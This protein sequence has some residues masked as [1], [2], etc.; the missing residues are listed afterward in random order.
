MTDRPTTNLPKTNLTDLQSQLQGLWLPLVT[1]FRDGALDEPQLRRLV[2][3]YAGGPVDGLILAATSGEGMALG[4]AELERL[5]MAVR[6]ELSASQRTCRSASGC[7]APRPRRCWMRWM[8][9]RPGRSM[10]I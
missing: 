7:R 10:A 4:I 6:A 1:P 8:R 9:R 2:R 5:V 3:H